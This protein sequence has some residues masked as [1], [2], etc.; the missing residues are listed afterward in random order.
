MTD[1]DR[2]QCDSE[3]YIQPSIAASANAFDDDSS[4]VAV[5]PQIVHETCQNKTE[6]A[7]S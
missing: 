3:S 7:L 6:V 1:L 5:T 4:T 2:A